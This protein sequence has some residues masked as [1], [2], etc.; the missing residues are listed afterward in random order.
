LRLAQGRLRH[1]V[2][3]TTFYGSEQAAIQAFRLG[4]RDY[5]IKPYE[6]KEM[7]ESVERALIERRLRRETMDL[8][9]APRS[10]GISK[11]GSA[12]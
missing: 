5:I 11:T 4:A 6:V 9:E 3:L 8:K 12:S 2:I 7:L 1:P 10:A